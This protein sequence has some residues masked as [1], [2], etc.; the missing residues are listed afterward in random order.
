VAGSADA[1]EAEGE[2]EGPT[3]AETPDGSEAEAEIVAVERP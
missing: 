2:E 3:L 1:S